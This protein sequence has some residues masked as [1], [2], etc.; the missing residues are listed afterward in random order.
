MTPG[1][2]FPGNSAM[3]SE[4]RAKRGKA[5]LGTQGSHRAP[6]TAGRPLGGDLPAIHGTLSRKEGQ[7]LDNLAF[8][9]NK[10]YDRPTLGLQPVKKRYSGFPV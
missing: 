8:C 1:E 2:P 7:Y 10:K 3:G 6:R 4:R 9:E 5:E